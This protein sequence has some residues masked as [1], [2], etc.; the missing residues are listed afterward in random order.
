PFGAVTTSQGSL[1]ALGGSPASP[2]LPSVSRT[3]PSGLNL[4]TVWPFPFASGNFWSSSCVA[5]R[6]SVTQ[7][8]PSLSTWIPCGNTNIPPPKLFTNFPDESNLRT[9]G[10]FDP[11]HELTPQRSA[12][13]IDLPSGS[14]STADNEPHVLPSGKLP[15]FLNV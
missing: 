2:G 10:R 3:L 1:R 5:A 11:A 7:T 4:T 14:T 15:Q 8:L 6:A 13:Q 12:T 9:A